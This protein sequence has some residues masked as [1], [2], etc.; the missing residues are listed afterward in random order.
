MG[1][2][3]PIYMY[4]ELKKQFIDRLVNLDFDILAICGD[5]FDSKFMSN[6]LI[7]SY[8]VQ[9]VNDIVN[10]CASRNATLIIIDGTQSHDNGQ[11]SLFYHY[12]YNEYVDVRIVEKIQFENV[13]GLRVLC[14]PERY[15][16]PEEEYNQVL[17]NSGKYDLCLLH[18]TFKGS[19]K[20][21]EIA[22][23][24][25]NHAPVFSMNSF[26]NCAGPILMGHYHKAGCYEEY[27]YYN[28]SALRFAFGEE[29]EKGFLVTLYNPNTRR[30]YTELIPIDSYIYNT[31][32]INHLINSDPKDII[33]YIK[34]IKEEQHIDFI[35]VQ[36]NNANENMNIVRN[37]FRNTNNVKFKELDKRDKQMQQ[38]D[39]TILEQ[40]MQYSYL[41]DNEISDYDK[42]VMYA[43]QNEGYDFITTDELIKLLEEDL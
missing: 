36:F 4:T 14:I 9:L 11:L 23:L 30:H 42:F 6:N 43:N 26:C 1:V 12:M 37:Y 7:V 13:N 15:G 34:R 35:R 8:T 19:Y 38:I 2:L 5:L 24:K 31:I 25:S 32:N 16:I 10:L 21:A 20:G 3:D 17:F 18:G 33:E 39:Q 29:E 28:G 27:A 22:T 41:L 40:N